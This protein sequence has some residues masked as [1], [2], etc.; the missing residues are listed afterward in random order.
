MHGQGASSLACA[1][2][3]SGRPECL[4]QNQNIPKSYPGKE[5][6]E[7]KPPHGTGNFA[8]LTYEAV[9]LI[10]DREG[11]LRIYCV[12]GLQR[13]CDTTLASRVDSS[14]ADC[15]LAAVDYVL[16]RSGRS[17]RGPAVSLFVVNSKARASRGFS[18]FRR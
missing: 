3:G 10:H 17:A 18:D 12:R 16:L 5:D 7:A 1:V 14:G 11:P 6:H 9:A 8:A 13:V 4:G 2:L 15:S